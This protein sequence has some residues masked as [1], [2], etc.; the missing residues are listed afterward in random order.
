MQ[1]VGRHLFPS[2]SSLQKDI[3]SDLSNHR[4][5]I[6]IL[7][8][9]REHYGLNESVQVYYSSSLYHSVIR[10]LNSLA[11]KGFVKIGHR[12][13]SNLYSITPRGKDYLFLMGI[14]EDDKK[15]GNKQSPSQE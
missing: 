5:P 10:S 3:L 9:F 15:E 8:Y 11:L 4:E 1:S 7:E 13:R 14:K 2:T 12:G 6:T